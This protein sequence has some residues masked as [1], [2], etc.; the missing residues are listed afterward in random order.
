MAIVHFRVFIEVDRA[1]TGILMVISGY[2]L[3]L[4]NA[5]GSF[6]FFG[7]LA[8]ISAVCYLNFEFYISLSLGKDIAYIK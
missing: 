2:S 6:L 4:I 3:F 8:L 1:R 5:S 7:L